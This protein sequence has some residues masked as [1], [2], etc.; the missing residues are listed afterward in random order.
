MAD[1]RTLMGGTDR[2]R[3][4]AAQLHEISEFASRHGLS[5]DEARKILEETAPDRRAADAAAER[6]RNR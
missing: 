1:D 3:T 2:L 5:T 6:F 4:P